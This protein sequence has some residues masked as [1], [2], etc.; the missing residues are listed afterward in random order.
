VN[1]LII[2][3][4]MYVTG[5]QGSGAGTVLSS[6]AELSRSLKIDLV[7][8]VGTKPDNAAVVAE[9]M[10][11]INCSI[12]THL[13]ADY[14]VINGD[15]HLDIPLLCSDVRYDCAIISV[16]DHLHYA[17][18][19]VLL[20]L[21]IAILVVKPLT[22][23]VE[24]A[25]DLIAVQDRSGAYAAVEFHKRWDATNLWVQRYSIYQRRI[26]PKNIHSH[27][28]FPGVVPQD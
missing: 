12:G 11:R 4:G 22:P 24:E 16:P 25:R 9:A 17:Y 26:Q 21:K 7:T 20:E 8:V 27:H 10:E 23:T 28:N 6:L 15:A 13:R 14:R 19:K 18:A 5:R 1:V 2:G 3:A